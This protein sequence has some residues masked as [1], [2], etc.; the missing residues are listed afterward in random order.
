[1]SEYSATAPAPGKSTL[2]L[3]FSNVPAAGRMETPP[4][5]SSNRTSTAVEPSTAVVS[6]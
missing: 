2:P 3:S 1:M 6:P 5:S 4:L